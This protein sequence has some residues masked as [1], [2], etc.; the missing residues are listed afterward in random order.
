MKIKKLLIPILIRYLF[1]L[2]NSYF[3][4]RLVMLDG[5]GIFPILLAAFASRDFVQASQLA[6]VYYHLNSMNKK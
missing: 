5:W 3:T 1:F 4:V 2:I 6:K